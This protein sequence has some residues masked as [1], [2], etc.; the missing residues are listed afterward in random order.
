MITH[1]EKIMFPAAGDEPAITKGELAAY[2]EAIAPVMLPHVAGRPVTM[3]RYPSGIDK[4][5]FWQK[6]VS[7]GFPDW[8]ER[9]DVPKKDGVVHHP[10]IIDTRSLLWV[11][12]QNTVTQHVWVS[13][14]PNLYFPDVCV[15][16]RTAPLVAFSPASSVRRPFLKCPANDLATETA[17]LAA[18]GS[19]VH[20]RGMPEGAPR[21]SAGAAAL[22]S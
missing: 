13:R 20:L 21:V 22:L 12:N 16:D 19:A 9:V 15:I 7:R 18:P 11:T 8:L 17:S 14:V 2:Y 3:E 10:L 1:P 5:G 6:S 4:E